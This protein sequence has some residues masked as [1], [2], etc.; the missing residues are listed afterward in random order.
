MAPFRAATSA[1]GGAC[2][3]SCTTITVWVITATSTCVV[4]PVETCDRRQA[5]GWRLSNGSGSQCTDQSF[6]C[7]WTNKRAVR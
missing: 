2:A 6:L 4:R 7:S 5:V 3:A 1:A